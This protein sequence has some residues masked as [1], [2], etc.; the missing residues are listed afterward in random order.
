MRSDG[1]IESF[2]S[3][4]SWIDPRPLREIRGVKPGSGSWSASPRSRSV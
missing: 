2:D 4:R 1:S 3:T